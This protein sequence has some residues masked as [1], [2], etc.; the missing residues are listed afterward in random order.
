MA[1]IGQESPEL[2]AFRHHS[3]ALIHAIDCPDTFAWQLSANDLIS[4]ETKS[5]AL[6]LQLSKEQKNSILL[7][8]V[9]GKI[10]AVISLSQIYKSPLLW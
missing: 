5:Q 9:E 6:V 8:A 7:S 1:T 3:F 4:D 2:C 10:R